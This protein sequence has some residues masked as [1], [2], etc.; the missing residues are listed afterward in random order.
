MIS[1]K[2]NEKYHSLFKGRITNDSYEESIKK[3]TLPS[4]DIFVQI[5][6]SR[7]IAGE[8][9]LFIALETALSSFENSSN[10]TKIP[11][12]ELI[13]RI[14]GKKQLNDALETAKFGKENL[15]LI[16][17]SRK[18]KEIEKI[19]KE[20]NFKEKNFTLGKNKKYLEKL[21]SVS[22]AELNSLKDLKNPLEELVI[23]RC[24]F[25]ALER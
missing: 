18:K 16:I 20:L 13:V 8:T 15:V 24:A 2:I 17:G 4:K 1:K 22:K 11:A 10:F 21:F 6:P 12:L 25:V 14:L 9:H 19:K 5:L 3:L 23:E 7:I